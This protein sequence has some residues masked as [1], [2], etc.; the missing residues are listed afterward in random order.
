[1]IP[2]AAVTFQYGLRVN[3]SSKSGMTFGGGVRAA[4]R[5]LVSVYTF[6]IILVV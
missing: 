5:G 6:A 2:R 4:F 1:M 3:G